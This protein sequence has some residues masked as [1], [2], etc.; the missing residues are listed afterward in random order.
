MR[1]LSIIA[2]F[3]TFNLSAQ[4]YKNPVVEPNKI[5]DVPSSLYEQS[6]SLNDY[7]VHFYHLDLSAT[8]SNTTLSGN[9]IIESKVT[10][11]LNSFICELMGYMTV[12]SVLIND[13]S[14]S[15]SHSNNIITADC[16]KTFYPNENIKVQ[17]FYNGTVTGD[18]YS[19][20][21]DSQY[22]ATYSWTLSESIHARDWFPCK[23]VLTDK[24]DSVFIDITVPKDLTVASNGLLVK[25]ENTGSDKRKFCWQTR[26]P[27]NYYLISMTIANYQQY[28]LYASPKSIAPQ[29][30]LIQNFIY[31]SASYLNTN[32][33]NI[34]KT[35]DLVEYYSDVLGI[36]P[37]YKE[38]YGNAVAQLNGGMEHQTITTLVNFG[39]TLNAHELAHQWF[40]DYV[41]CGSWQD[42][43]INEGF[44]SYCEYIA[45]E[46]FYGAAQAKGWMEIAQ[47]NAK[48]KPNSSVYIPFEELTSENRIFDYYLSYK[49]GAAIIHTLR[50]TINNDDQ[51]FEALKTYLDNYK[52]STATGDDFFNNISSTTGINLDNFKNDWYYGKGFPTYK[53]DWKQEN[54]E[55]IITVS[56][57]GSSSTKAFFYQPIEIL[58]N[59]SEGNRTIIFNPESTSTTLSFPETKT[60]TNLQI[61][62]NNYIIKGTTSYST[63]I[64]SE[65]KRDITLLQSAANS[66]FK[67]IIDEKY[68]ENTFVITDIKGVNVM[69]FKVNNTESVINTNNLKQGIY[70]LST[71]NYIIGKIVTR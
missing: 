71:N 21:T 66:Y 42:I 27:I 69:T 22:G 20:G 15:F 39:F 31:N 57:T 49:K 28:N 9:I 65:I 70:I 18:G 46:K 32:K 62:P 54:S 43:W 48:N 26:Y 6:E 29:T 50:G 52:N 25:T 40:G 41:T 44:A 60:V 64:A 45:L 61:D 53:I 59:Y 16:N 2:L 19:T 8:N 67:I 35:K 47:N 63:D 1:K 10:K 58:V 3:V 33:A 51:F 12:S 55:L 13:V 5:P 68:L 30:I 4:V 38:K 56:Q 23:Q 34:D 14:V 11:Q 36:Y 7:D 17:I 37:F 24:I